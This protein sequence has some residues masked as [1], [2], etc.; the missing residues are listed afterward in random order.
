MPGEPETSEAGT[1]DIFAGLVLDEA[2]VLAAL[3]HEPTADER[4]RALRAG[5]KR[6]GRAVAGPARH[7][8]P[9]VGRSAGI[10]TRRGRYQAAP[11]RWQRVVARMMLVVIGMLAVLV[12]A[13][14]VYRGA[15]PGSQ[16]VP[17]PSSG[18]GSSSSGSAA[19]GVPR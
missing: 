13:A 2:F 11:G 4:L 19:A 16:P 3:I 17:G 7:A 10:I 9:E 1:P 6:R 5:A 15:A 14:A 8:D 12:A 18:V